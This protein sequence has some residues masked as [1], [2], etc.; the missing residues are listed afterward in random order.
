MSKTK[1]TLRAELLKRMEALSAEAVEAASKGA[2][3]QALEAIDWSSVH[4]VLVYRPIG[5]EID[6]KFLLD[7]LAGIEVKIVE[8]RK[9]ATVSSGQYDVILLP[10]IGFNEEHYRIG[11]GGGWYDRLLVAH[12]KAISIGLA[13]SWSNADFTP[14]S[15]DIPLDYIYSA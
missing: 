3:C 11:R 4:R 15:H 6:P 14:E 9:D 7:A 13:Y 1:A 5:G 10:V 2:C 12:P 8:T